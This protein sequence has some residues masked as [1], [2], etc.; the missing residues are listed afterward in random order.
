[1][2]SIPKTIDLEKIRVPILTIFIL[3]DEERYMAKCV[4]LDLV[5]EMDT[6]EEALKAI[7]EMIKEY[8]EDYKKREE[9]FIK[10]PNRRHHKPYVEEVLKCK[11]L[12]DI[13]QLIKVQY[14]YIYL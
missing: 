9:L 10:S 4:E 14:G 1:M 13:Y 2:N 6:P 3:K 11:D 12:W 7:V 5:T 8:S